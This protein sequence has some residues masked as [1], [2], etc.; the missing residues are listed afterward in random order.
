MSIQLRKISRENL[1][2]C[3]GLS[4]SEDQHG[5]VATNAISIAQAYVE[6]TFVPMAIYAGDVMVGFVM[7]GREAETGYDWIIRLMVDARYQGRGYG[8]A[9]MLEVLTILQ[10]LP[11]SKGIR[12]SY[13]PKNRAAERLYQQVGF[14]AT[15]E[16]EDGEVVAQ[17]QAQG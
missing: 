11:D 7:Y 12:I 3:I 16:V 10:Q 1:F 8:R 17:F 5:F 4:I 13:S 2:E 6:P 14:G 9:T 15:G